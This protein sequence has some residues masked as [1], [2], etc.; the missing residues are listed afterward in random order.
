MRLTVYTFA[1]AALFC[2]V[3]Y[4]ASPAAPI[5]PPGGLRTTPSTSSAADTHTIT[6]PLWLS[7]LLVAPGPVSLVPLW[8]RRLGLLVA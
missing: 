8:R 6:S 4:E 5:A 3:T 7:P 1:V 2:A